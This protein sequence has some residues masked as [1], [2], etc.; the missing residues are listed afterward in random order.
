M[1][2]RRAGGASTPLVVPAPAGLGGDVACPFVIVIGPCLPS[3]VT[4]KNPRH[5]ARVPLVCGGSSRLASVPPCPSVLPPGAGNE[6]AEKAV[7]TDQERAKKGEERTVGETRAVQGHLDAPTVRRHDDGDL[8]A[9]PAIEQTQCGL[10][11]LPG[12]PERFA[13]ST[14]RPVIVQPPGLHASA[15]LPA[16]RKR[17]NRRSAGGFVSPALRRGLPYFQR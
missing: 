4:S 14:G 2:L 11:A 10:P 17:R 16:P 9:I 8:A 15:R 12:R 3:S 13:Q 5:P 1:W 6:K 7:K